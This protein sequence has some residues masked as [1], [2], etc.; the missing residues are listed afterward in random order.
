MDIYNWGILF[1][2]W[3]EALLFASNS[4][5]GKEIQ[6]AHFEKEIR[7]RYSHENPLPNVNLPGNAQFDGLAGLRVWCTYRLVLPL[8]YKD[9]LLGSSRGD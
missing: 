5:D 7:N 6:T 9:K 2:L 8:Q 4:P 1:R 3:S